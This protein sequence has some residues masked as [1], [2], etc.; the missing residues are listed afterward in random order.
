M[1]DMGAGVVWQSD[2]ML[3]EMIN[4]HCIASDDPRLKGN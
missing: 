4:E 1:N 2:D 3:R